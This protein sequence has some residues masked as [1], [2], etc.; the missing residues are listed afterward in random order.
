MSSVYQKYFN[1]EAIKLAFH[2][3]QCWTDKT[4]KDQVGLR[5]FA[6]NLD[7]NCK[8]FSEKILL[9]NY[10][11]QR[12]FKFYVPKS[13]KTLR[14]K[15]VLFL[16]DA[17]VYQ[18]IVNVIAKQ[19]YDTLD[20]YSQFVYGSI[21][22]EEVK[23]GTEILNE[24]KPNF[25]FFKH[26]QGLRN[27]YSESI[28]QA[29]EIEKVKYKFETDITGFFDSIPHYNLLLKLCEEYGVEDEILDILG[30]CL[31]IW[32][33]TKSG[34]TPGVGIPQGVAPSFLL[35]NLLLNKL[36][37]ELVE[38]GF[39]YYRYMDDISI[40]SY[41]EDELLDALLIIDKYTKANA[42]SIN[43]KKTSIQEIKEGVEDDKVKELK[44]VKEFF[45]YDEEGEEISIN[46]DYKNEN[47]KVDLN[48]DL[49]KLSQ[50]DNFSDEK[51]ILITDPKQLIAYW[52]KQIKEI[53]KELLA[54]FVDHK[55]EM[56]IL[57]EKSDDIDAIRLSS[58]FS[59]A[60]RELKYLDV[61]VEPDP[62]LLKYWIFLYEKYFWRADKLGYT[63]MNYKNSN[64][65]KTKL[66]AMLDRVLSKYEYCRYLIF[67]N[68]SLTQNF[69]EKEL[70]QV[71]FQLLKKETSDL[72][73]I[74]LYRLLY[75]HCR[76]NQFR[77][78]LDNQLNKEQNQ[79]LKE[80]IA[81][82]NRFHNRENIN[83]EEFL[84]SIGL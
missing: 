47:I 61:E 49:A 33:G 23:K 18:A 27:K 12:G 78:T 71:Y 22:N 14:T 55:A 11:P 53:K 70:R 59:N 83:L 28:I 31:N 77:A 24:E 50:Q 10:K 57:K 54:L 80:V 17:I 6:A 76:T 13:S 63:L 32:S 75:N 39:R 51:S 67:Q 43:A 46:K 30:D 2:R 68:I 37:H 56:L 84:N 15:G 42:L 3:V 65:V 73:K 7:K 26:W 4:V 20:Q 41:D 81:D 45:S 40:Y 19:S 21:L 69:D 58:R 9:G 29:I 82:F 5:A 38:H 62:N 25:F 36:D 52:K 8:S 79:Y 35:A 64:E 74:S 60:L 16:E 66:M 72:V 44:K 34:P 48:K 1:P